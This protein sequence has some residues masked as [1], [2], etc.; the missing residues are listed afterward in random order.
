MKKKTE[1]TL[2]ERICFIILG[3]AFLLTGLVICLVSV[4]FMLFIV[5]FFTFIPG[6]LLVICG[7]ALLKESKYKGGKTWDKSLKLKAKNTK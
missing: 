7:Y 2:I 6:A 1:R 4:P 5:G 3:S